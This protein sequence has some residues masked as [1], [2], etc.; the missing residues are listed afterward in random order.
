MRLGI[1]RGRW[2]TGRVV[3]HHVRFWPTM[4]G[5]GAWRYGLY[6]PPGLRDDEAAPLVVL[7]HGCRQRALGFAYAAGWTRAADLERF[8]LLCPEQRRL[9]NLWRCWNWFHPLAQAGQGELQVIDRV[10][11]EVAARVRIDPGRIAAV[12]FS[13]GGALAALLAFHRA[14]RFAAAATVAAP[15]LTGRFSLRDPRDVIRRGLLTDPR[16][17]LGAR[18]EACAPLLIAH[19][20]A[21]QIVTPRCAE[22]LLAQALECWRRSG[23]ALQTAT[24][25]MPDAIGC[26]ADYRHGGQ[27][28]LRHICLRGAGHSWTGGPGG[29]PFCERGGPPLTTIVLRYLRDL[30]LLTSRQRRALTSL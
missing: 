3:V 20:D 29:H 7:L 28:I 21:D 10:L 30:G 14:A 6:L 9:A 22:Q 2:L 23:A 5:A 8:R 19:G 13:A 16:L 25:D 4:P 17:A 11:E 24:T 1:W 12:G 27:L 18:T 15:P 26:G